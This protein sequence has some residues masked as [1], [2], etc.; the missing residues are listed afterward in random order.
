[1]NRNLDLLVKYVEILK[2]VFDREKDHAPF[3]NLG[4]VILPDHLHVIWRLPNDDSDYSDRWRR[5]KANFSKRV[6]ISATISDSRKAKGERGIW[7]RR[8]WEHTIRDDEDLNNHL[9]YIHYNPV[10]HGLVSRVID[11]PHSS[12][13]EYVVRGKYNK[14]W[15]S[16]VDIKGEFGE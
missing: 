8:F 5:I 14:N 1:M 16:G 7:Q 3:T 6:P 15:G 12:F 2:Q 11:W 13:H 10:K 4:F 9:D